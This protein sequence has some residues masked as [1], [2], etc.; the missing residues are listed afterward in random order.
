[1]SVLEANLRTSSPKVMS[2]YEVLQNIQKDR[3]RS[4]LYNFHALIVD[5]SRGMHNK[6][7][8]NQITESLNETSS[9][10]A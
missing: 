1:M 5:N 7:F 4:Q 2:K 3:K 6:K 8:S 9:E 10:A